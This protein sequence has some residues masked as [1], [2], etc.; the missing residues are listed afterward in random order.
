MKLIKKYKKW[1]G[2]KPKRNEII[3]VDGM[4]VK[5]NREPAFATCQGCCLNSTKQCHNRLFD[6]EENEN[7]KIVT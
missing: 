4:I 6:C 2:N 1:D 7:F 3:D 5:L